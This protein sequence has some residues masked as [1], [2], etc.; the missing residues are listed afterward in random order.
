MA[1]MNM[2]VLQ[3]T[4]PSF[5]NAIRYYNIEDE[6]R[7]CAHVKLAVKTNQKNEQTGYYESDIFDVV[8][9]GKS[10]Q[11]LQKWGKP[12]TALIVQGTLLPPKARIDANGAPMVGADGKTVYSPMTLRV[13]T[14]YFQE[15]SSAANGNH[16]AAVAP[17]PAP[18]PIDPLAGMGAPAPAAAPALPEFPFPM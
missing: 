3:G 9:F 5:E 17:T 14:F 8:F 18:Q 12:K 15:G 10:A 2:F 4:I 16:K 6:K 11:S 7:A 1:N 13:S